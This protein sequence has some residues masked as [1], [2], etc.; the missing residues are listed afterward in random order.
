MTYWECSAEFFSLESEGTYFWVSVKHGVINTAIFWDGLWHVHRIWRFV[1]LGVWSSPAEPTNLP[2]FLAS[3]TYPH[4]TLERESYIPMSWRIYRGKG[5]IYW[6]WRCPDLSIPQSRLF[7]NG[8]K[9]EWNKIRFQKLSLS[10]QL[11]METLLPYYPCGDLLH[12]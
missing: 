9:W 3:P 10:P 5:D 8:R 1:N 12:I 7:L 6:C 4:Q 11:K 2:V